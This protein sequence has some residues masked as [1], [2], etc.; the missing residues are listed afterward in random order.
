MLEWFGNIPKFLITL[1][2]DYCAQAA[3]ADF[4]ALVEFALPPGPEER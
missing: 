4:C 3:D 2:A 1:A